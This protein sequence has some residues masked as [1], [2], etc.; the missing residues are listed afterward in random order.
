MSGNLNMGNNLIS[1]LPTAN[2]PVYQGNGTYIYAALCISYHGTHILP[3]DKK[4]NVRCSS[5]IASL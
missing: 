5:S 3:V 2:P 4:K 1:G